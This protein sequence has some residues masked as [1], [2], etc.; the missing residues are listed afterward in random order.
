[1]SLS[2]H[3]ANLPRPLS[4]SLLRPLRYLNLMRGLELRF[5]APWARQV[6]GKQILDVGCGHGLYSLELARKG[7]TLVGCDLDLPS[8]ED[9]QYASTGLELLDRTVFLAADGS[10]LPVPSGQ[11]DLVVCN[12]VLEHIADDNAAL[13][14]MVRALRPGGVL[15]LTV[16]S[17]EHGLALRLVAKLPR[18]IQ[19]W[20]LHPEILAAESPSVGLDARLDK[21]Y[22]VRR[23]YRSAE[24]ATK[25]E[26]LGMTILDSRPYLSGVG[27][28][29]YEAFHMLRGLDPGKGLGRLLY[30]SSSLALYPFAAMSDNRRKARGHGLSIAARKE[31]VRA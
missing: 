15:Y 25:I 28:A 7:A 9:A 2:Q 21:L 22:A 11:F 19:R 1:M 12:C 31:G 30:M 4:R 26:S 16:D 24:L 6:E 29:H 8:L 18:A 20:L 13:A 23:R 17:E 14:D 5:M 27:A 3:L 10:T